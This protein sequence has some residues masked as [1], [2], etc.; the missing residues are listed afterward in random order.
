MKRIRR[1]L[2]LPALLLC[3]LVLV[4]RT[5]GDIHSSTELADGN[6]SLVADGRPTETS[7]VNSSFFVSLEADMQLDDDGNRTTTH[8]DDDRTSTT[9][10][11]NLSNSTYSLPGGETNSSIP[12]SRQHISH[13]GNVTSA[14]SR[15]TYASSLRH[16]VTHNSSP[17]LRYAD[18]TEST[19]DPPSLRGSYDSPPST[20]SVRNTIVPSLTLHQQTSTG[21]RSNQKQFDFNP[22]PSVAPPPTT[23]PTTAMMHHVGGPV[24]VHSGT[25]FLNEIAT[26]TF[27]TAPPPTPPLTHSI[28]QI[29][30]LG[31]VRMVQTGTETAEKSGFTG[32]DFTGPENRIL[33]DDCGGCYPL[34]HMDG[35]NVVMFMK[36]E[37]IQFL[38]YHPKNPQHLKQQLYKEQGKFELTTNLK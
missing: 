34:I 33:S 23:A 24:N 25:E 27:D 4:C 16:G 38:S 31:P 37:H 21:L 6:T 17:L 9:S 8:Q 26:S 2:A 35:D 3:T 13:N 15:S 14:E 5:L 20:S 32:P 7:V 36:N 12:S 11:G 19:E 18:E 22:H 30:V 29:P 28:A 1:A 10:T